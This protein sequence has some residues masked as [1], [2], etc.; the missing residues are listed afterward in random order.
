MTKRHILVIGV[1]LLSLTTCAIAPATVAAID[2]NAKE[3]FNSSV[4]GTGGSDATALPELIK[5]TINIMLYIAGVIAVV[6]IVV[7]SLRFVTSEGDAQAA[8]KAKNSVVYALV[9]LVVAV[10]AYAIVNFV[11]N[12]L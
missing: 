4:G 11:L 8:N 5:N 9:G 10:L 12:G 1:F 6:I 3:K 7:G 2:S